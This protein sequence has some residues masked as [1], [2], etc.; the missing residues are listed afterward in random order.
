MRNRPS[1][2]LFAT[3]NIT[4]KCNLS[5]KYCFFQ[6]RINIDMD[7]PLFINVVDELADES[8]FFI[9]I[10]GGEPFLHPQINDILEYSHYKFSHVVVLTNGM[11]LSEDNCKQIEKIY[12]RKKTFPIQI[13][14]DSIFDKV[15]SSTRG[16]S[17]IVLKN[18]SKLHSIG[19][20][21]VIAMVITRNNVNKLIESIRYLTRYTTF[22][23]IMNLQEVRYDNNLIENLSLNSNE[24]ENIWTEITMLKEE[25]SLTIEI[26]CKTDRFADGC[27]FGAPCMAGFSH[28]VIDPD[29]KVRPC[30][31]LTNTRVGDMSL[32]SLKQLW[33]SA[34]LQEIIDSPM[35]YCQVKN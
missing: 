22:F 2:P 17:K 19:A 9:N 34:E 13:S 20:N 12:L 16:Q 14:L 23:H 21:I 15:N 6:P 28:I 4:G 32:T 24:S 25:L 1:S 26:P 3:I 29:L 5:C 8:V 33:A 27:A 30:D 31:R 7:F 11:I 18:L 10:S 35:P